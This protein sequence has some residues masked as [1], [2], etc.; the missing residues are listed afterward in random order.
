MSE[1]IK[2]Q[3]KRVRIKEGMNSP[4]FYDDKSKFLNRDMKHLLVFLL[5]FVGFIIIL[6]YSWKQ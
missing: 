2:K 6:L 4:V 1:P 3:T 5:W